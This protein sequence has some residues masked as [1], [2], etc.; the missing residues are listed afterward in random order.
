MTKTKDTSNLWRKTVKT[1]ELVG[2]LVEILRLDWTITEACS[3]ANIGRVSYYEWL[4]KDKEFANKMEDAKEYMFIEARKT[5]VKAVREWDWKL[6]LDVMRRRDARY[7]DKS[8]ADHT[9]EITIWGILQGIQ[10]KKE[11]K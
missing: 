3:Y 2:K 1:E 4:K 7:K 9:G 5:I 8:E 10:A 11:E 6:A